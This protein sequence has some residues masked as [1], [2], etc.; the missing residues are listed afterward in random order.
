[1]HDW[2]IG[3][4]ADGTGVLG[5]NIDLVEST[6]IKFQINDVFCT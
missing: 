1:M 5:A 3:F 6:Y 2:M 4:A